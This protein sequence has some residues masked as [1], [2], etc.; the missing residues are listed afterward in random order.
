MKKILSLVLVLSIALVSAMAFTGCG[1]KD[2][3]NVSLEE[4]HQA[5]KDVYGEDYLPNME[6]PAD[7][8]STLMGVTEDMYDEVIAEMPMISVNI[9]TFIAVKAKEGKGADVAAALNSYKDYLL[10]ES[11]QYPINAAKLPASQ[12]IEHGDYVFFVLLGAISGETEM[13]TEEEILAAMQTEN[14]KAVDAINSFF[15]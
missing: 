1:K 12:V 3:T 5:V 14:Q 2:V 6:I 8:L 4:V 10:N 15:E 13:G 7:T 11:M 9:D